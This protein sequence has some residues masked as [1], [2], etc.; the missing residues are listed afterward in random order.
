[1]PTSSAQ[2]VAPAAVIIP[3]GGTTKNGS[4][5]ELRGVNYPADPPVG[6]FS[7]YRKR[8]F[9]DE[10]VQQDDVPA[11]FNAVGQRYIAWSPPMKIRAP[12]RV[13]NSKWVFEDPFGNHA[14]IIKTTRFGH[15]EIQEVEVS[16]AGTAGITGA[17]SFTVEMRTLIRPI[18]DPEVAISVLLPGQRWPEPEGLESEFG[19]WDVGDVAA[20]DL[21][22]MQQ[23]LTQDP[24]ALARLQDSA[25]PLLSPSVEV[26][27]VSVEP[28]RLEIGSDEVGRCTL[29]LQVMG[30][31]ILP[32]ALQAVAREAF[33]E[34]S[35]DD[36]EVPTRLQNVLISEIMML[37][38]T[39][40]NRISLNEL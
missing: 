34:P 27:D 16:V 30:E 3:G 18:K 11:N 5:M 26:V 39:D 31:A 25:S 38:T 6:Y 37:D 8:V 20:Y 32:F 10:Y 2:Q 21:E 22:E 9:F 23:A 19:F 33:G 17:L 12:S 36:V 35:E 29:R 40:P 24:E 4:T 13:L 15:F 14:G 28:T 1:M 7:L